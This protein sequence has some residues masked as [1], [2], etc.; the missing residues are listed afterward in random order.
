MNTNATA[1]TVLSLARS[2]RAAACYWSPYHRK[3]AVKTA[4]NVLSRCPGG[5]RDLFILEEGQFFATPGVSYGPY[6]DGRFYETGVVAGRGGATRV[7]TIGPRGESRYHWEGI[8]HDASRLNG[9]V[10]AEA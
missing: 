9:K 8:V 3:M 7:E 5:R 4:A 1:V 2:I 10:R 6:L